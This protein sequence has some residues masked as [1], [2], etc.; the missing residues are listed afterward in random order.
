MGALKKPKIVVNGRL[1]SLKDVLSQ[2]FNK[3]KEG[4]RLLGQKNNLR[5]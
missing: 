2:T 5:R 3:A 4:Q 1:Q